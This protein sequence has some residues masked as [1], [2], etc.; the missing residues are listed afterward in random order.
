M[1]DPLRNAVAAE[2]AQ[3][4]PYDIAARD[5]G[6]AAAPMGRRPGLV[7]PADG[8]GRVGVARGR[9]GVEEL[10]GSELAVED[11]AADEAVLL[12]HR[13]R[14]DHLAVQHRVGEP[15]RDG[16]HASHDPVGV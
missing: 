15:W 13:V 10:G 14:P 8:G 5:P 9:T 16:L 7:A 1:P 6:D 11:V 4:D 2:V 12:L 3:D